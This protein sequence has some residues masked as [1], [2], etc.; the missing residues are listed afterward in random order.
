MKTV[1]FD[2]ITI[3]LNFPPQAWKPKSESDS[4]TGKPDFI[5]FYCPQWENTTSKQR[6]KSDK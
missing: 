3:P 5:D 4:N 6:R 1:V 2:E